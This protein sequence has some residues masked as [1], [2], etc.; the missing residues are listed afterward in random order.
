MQ[1][2]GKRKGQDWRI[3]RNRQDP[4]NTRRLSGCPRHPGQNAGEWSKM[5]A[6]RVWRH[7][8]I[9]RREACWI[10]VGIQDQTV[11]LTFQALNDMGEKRLASQFLHALVAAT[12][13]ARLSTGKKYSNGW[14]I[15]VGGHVSRKARRLS[16]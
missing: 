9:E 5:A 14:R 6:Q 15:F 12:H 11:D 16:L 4:R 13:P 2:G 7:G 10:A 1:C 3:S 8:Q